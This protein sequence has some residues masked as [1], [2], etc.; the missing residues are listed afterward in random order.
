MRIMKPSVTL[1]Q[2]QPMKKEHLLP[3][4]E[5]CGRVCYKSEDK[6]CEG[7]AEKFVTNI[8]NRG[9]EAVI[10]HGTLCFLAG[11]NV[12][13][14]M[15][16]FVSCLKEL[17]G[18]QGY[19]RFTNDNGRHII[20]GNIR[21]WRDFMGACLE[22]FDT[23]PFYLHRIA[24]NSPVF[25]PEYQDLE[26][27]DAGMDGAVLPILSSDLRTDNEKKAHMDLTFHFVVDRGVSHEI[28]RHRPA[29]YCQE[30]TRYCNYSKEKF[31]EEISVIEPCY[32]QDGTYGYEEWKMAMSASELAYFNLLN[33][34]CT[35]QQA[36]AVLPNSLKTELVMTAPISEWL[37]F[38]NLRLSKAAHPQMR[39]AALLAL[40][41]IRMR[42]GLEEIFEDQIRLYGEEAEQYGEEKQ[43]RTS[44]CTGE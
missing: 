33:Y 8:L 40:N 10:E 1:T 18:F 30:S 44:D 17:C 41:E 13:E 15:M 31:G 2:I 11:Q 35:P 24:E 22:C 38:F 32:L 37:H 12:Y 23:I 21:A 42:A 27:Y 9:H 29:S 7:S 16:A 39:E 36:R 6:I 20:S 19:L 14:T 43:S 4:I 34:G 25:F 26:L 28:V 5:S 3:H